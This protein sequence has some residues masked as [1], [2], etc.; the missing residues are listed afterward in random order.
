MAW[1]KTQN[2]NFIDVSAFRIDRVY[3]QPLK[4]QILDGEGNE[5]GTYRSLVAAKEVMEDLE[6]WLSGS[7]ESIYGGNKRLFSFPEENTRMQPNN[8]D[9]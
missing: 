6:R 9:L 8:E 3:G 5:L 2:G 1:I 7:G 4:A